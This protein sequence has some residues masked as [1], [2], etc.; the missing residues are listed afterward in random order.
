MKINDENI[1]TDIAVIKNQVI[2]IKLDVKDVR[3]KL[4][5]D[6]VVRQEFEPVKRFVYALVSLVLLTVVGALLALILK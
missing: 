4:E 3:D 2:D 5:A 6:Y 1:K